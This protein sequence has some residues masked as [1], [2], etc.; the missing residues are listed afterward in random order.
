M[1][2]SEWLWGGGG[3]VLPRIE[4]KHRL[5]ARLCALSRL[6]NARDHDGR[7]RAVKSERGAVGGIEE[8]LLIDHKSVASSSLASG[9]LRSKHAVARKRTGTQNSTP[10]RCLSG[11]PTREDQG[12]EFQRRLVLCVSLTRWDEQN[13]GE[14]IFLEFG[15]CT[16]RSAAEKAAA[17]LI[18][19][20][21]GKITYDTTI[22]PGVQ[23]KLDWQ[24]DNPHHG[25]ERTGVGPLYYL[26]TGARLLARGPFEKARKGGAA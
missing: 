4:A 12:T 14:E 26:L 18:R 16:G 19:E 9:D 2:P 6:G 21:A 23:T 8:L 11:E 13:V 7:L 22:D 1:L 10:P 20:H 5:Q 3:A 17:D 24:R 25:D 15:R